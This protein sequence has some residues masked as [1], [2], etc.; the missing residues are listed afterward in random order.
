MCAWSQMA[1]KSRLDTGFEEAFNTDY[2]LSRPLGSLS[3][4]EQIKWQKR[5]QGQKPAKAR[6]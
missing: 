1:R 5:F 4:Q 3:L 6:E 2:G